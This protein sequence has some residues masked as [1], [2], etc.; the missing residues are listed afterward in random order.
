MS[1]RA[2][3][4]HL[5]CSSAPACASHP[6]APF[7]SPPP[8]LYLQL[9]QPQPPGR[10]GEGFAPAHVVAEVSL[11]PQKV[12]IGLER[13]PVRGLMRGGP[14][15]EGRTGGGTGRPESDW[16]SGSQAGGFRGRRGQGHGAERRGGRTVGGG[17]HHRLLCHT[18]CSLP[19]CCQVAT[20]G[21][22][23]NVLLNNKPSCPPC[24]YTRPLLPGGH[25]GGVH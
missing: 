24:L 19:P 5:L 1:R 8:L 22:T 17:Q 20:A 7:P 9:L 13:R 3:A 25:G 4:P 23:A 18:C 10:A 12:S 14:R 21:C 16:R 15:A 11:L 2:A 6:A